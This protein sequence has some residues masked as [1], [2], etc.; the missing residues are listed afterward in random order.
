MND[1]EKYFHFSLSLFIVLRRRKTY[2]TLRPHQPYYIQVSPVVLQYGILF[3]LSSKL[4]GIN[5][6]EGGRKHFQDMSSAINPCLPCKTPVQTEDTTV[7]PPLLSSRQNNKLTNESK[8]DCLSDSLQFWHAWLDDQ[9]R[10]F[11]LIC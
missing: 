10:W 4:Q 8:Y 2:A 5:W 11:E 9:L 3:F 1:Q 6:V 7:P